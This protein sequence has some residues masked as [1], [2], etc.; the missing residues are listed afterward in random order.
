[1]KKHCD[2]CDSVISRAINDMGTTIS[3]QDANELYAIILD[4][5]M[6]ICECHIKKE[7]KINWNIINKIIEG[8]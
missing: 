7:I 6:C 4:D 8:S 2:K 5:D 1:M 3:A